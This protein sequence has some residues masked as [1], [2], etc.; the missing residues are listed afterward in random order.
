[1]GREGDLGRPYVSID[2]LERGCLFVKLELE[3]G[4]S[5]A[6]GMRIGWAVVLVWT[7]V[8]GVVSVMRMVLDEVCLRAVRCGGMSAS[9]S[10]LIRPGLANAVPGGLPV[11]E[12]GRAHV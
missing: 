9:S 6:N 7:S 1:M 11:V 10:S 2:D 3:L 5:E 8:S 4:L 12:I